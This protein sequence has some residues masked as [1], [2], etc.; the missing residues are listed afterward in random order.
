MKQAATLI[1]ARLK[2]PRA[3]AIAGSG[4]RPRSSTLPPECAFWQISARLLKVDP[5]CDLRSAATLLMS[6][7]ALAWGCGGWN[8]SGSASFTGRYGNTYSANYSRG[9]SFGGGG[10]YGGGFRGGYVSGPYGAAYIG[11]V[12]RRPY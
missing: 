1:H 10:Y 7:N 5:D 8:R 3:A 11:G 2:T 9:G 6:T 12:Y 4:D